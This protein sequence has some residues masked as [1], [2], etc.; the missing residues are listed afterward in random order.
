MLDNVKSYDI[1]ASVQNKRGTQYRRI[2]DMSNSWIGKIARKFIETRDNMTCCYCGTQC[3]KYNDSTFENRGI[4][5]TLDHIVP[6]KTLAESAMND[7]HFYAM[8]RDTKNLVL[9]CV[10]CNCSKQ[11]TELYTW[12]IQTGKNY[13][14]IIAEIARRIA[15]EK[16]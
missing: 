1:V 5:A 2:L 3:I 10:S 14:T 8:R 4:V 9:V 7:K 11:H 16:V 15:I 13:A 12:C 6:Q